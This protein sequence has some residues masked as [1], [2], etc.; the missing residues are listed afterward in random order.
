MS[1]P[2]KAQIKATNKID[3]K[4]RPKSTKETEVLLASGAGKT[5]HQH[6]NQ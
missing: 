5:G 3:Q 4:L 2:L 6:V 1:I